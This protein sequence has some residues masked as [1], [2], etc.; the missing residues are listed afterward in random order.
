VQLEVAVEIEA[1]GAA[2]ADGWANPGDY[3]TRTA[4][5]R[6]G[7]GRRLLH[8]GGALTSE[9]PRTL[10]ALHD[11]RLSAEQAEVIV[12]TI[13][14]LPVQ[15][16][17]R[18]QAE[19]ALLEAAGSL[20]ATELAAA[21]RALLELLDPDGHA[22]REEAALD[23]LERSAHLNRFLAIVEDGLGGVRVKGRGTVEDA[24]VIK[25][26][27][28]AL[29]APQPAT[30]PECGLEGTD[31]R[32]HGARTWDALVEA[33][34]RLADAEVLPSDHGMRARV[35]VTV[36]YDS[37]K[38][39]VGTGVLTTGERLSAAAV[40]KLGCDADLLPVVLGSAGQVLDVGR[41]Q[42]LVTTLL[43]LALIAR[44]KH[45]AF[46]GCRRPPIACDAHHIRHWADGGPTSLDNLVMLCRAHHTMI[47]STP[48][49][50]RLNAG[51][52]LPEFL[53]PPGRRLAPAFRDGLD[54]RDDWIRERRVRE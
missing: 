46:P 43:W 42:R 4:G 33:C 19:A 8:T 38:A 31:P 17:L 12:R 20:D 49:R 2:K 54:R 5:G 41:S 37:L 16:S 39:K 45:C 10:A 32:D 9:R 50:V 6:R 13:D 36:D 1:T 25:A 22:R 23:R 34:Q 26:A 15:A 53:P 14:K 28:A 35:I 3:L 44:D 51:D 7:S 24:A 52:L 48:W 29:S 27:L 47:H 30:D 40:R 18:E 11:G 21:G